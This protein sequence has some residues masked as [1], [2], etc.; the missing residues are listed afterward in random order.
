MLLPSLS[1]EGKLSPGPLCLPRVI[2]KQVP[3]DS[4]SSR[5]AQSVKC[6]TSAQVTVCGFKPL[7]GLCADRS[8]P[9]A[10]FEFCV[11][12]SAPSP[13]TLSLSCS[14]SQKLINIKKQ[15][16]KKREIWKVRPKKCISFSKGN[17]PVRG[18][19]GQCLCCLQTFGLEIF[20]YFQYR[21]WL[22]CLFS[23][24]RV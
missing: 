1:G 7:I 12:L 11:C 14:F 23:S 17:Q 15:I 6:P 3:T 13:F 20:P 16:N 21:N 18:R 10:C 2:F 5:V 9:G 4:K 22:L 19:P 8:E 24:F